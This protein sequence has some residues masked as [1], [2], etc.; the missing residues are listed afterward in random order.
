MPAQTPTSAPD[1]VTKL[2]QK[3]PQK[4][5]VIWHN[6]LFMTLN[7][8]AAVIFT[9]IYFMH[10]SLTWGL[11]AF[12]AITYT[13]SNM[14]ITTGYH[15][16]FAHRTYA[17][18][19][20]VE[21]LFIFVGAGSFQGSVLSWSTDHRRHHSKVDSHDDPY[22]R[23]KGF[24]YAHFWWLFREDAHPDAKK[25]PND[26][27]KSKAIMFQHKYYA[28]V[29]TF[30]GYFVPAFVG[31]ACGFG[32]WGG[33]VIGG[34][35]RIALSQNST[36]LINSAAHT[37]GTRPYTDTNSARDS[38]FLSF[39]TFG[40][41]YH[42]YHHF[43]QLDYRN[44]IRWYQ[45]DPTKWAIRG[46]HTMGLASK[47]KKVR[48]EEIFKAKFAMEE[49][50][51][52]ELIAAKKHTHTFAERAANLRTHILEAQNKLRHLHDDY[53]NAK[54]NFSEKRKQVSGE[55]RASMR[56]HLSKMKQ[57]RNA[58]MRVAKIEFKSAYSQWRSLRKDVSRAA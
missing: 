50:Y 37:W 39:L 30:V 4:Q 38:F 43:F 58:Q 40:E 57:T 31:W 9:T 48:K 52:L 17:A 10:H 18:H 53:L 51:V 12:L 54:K 16:L 5:P 35:L 41:G 27:T 14:V 24:W 45:W 49:K 8:I 13:I 11:V 28:L 22:S 23:S 42:N 6:V 47:L 3:H 33:L 19:P 21:W 15:R 25:Y 2:P 36:F 29:A 7:P 46:L 55:V 1:P 34:S 56:A 32:F 26:L 44:G 20:V